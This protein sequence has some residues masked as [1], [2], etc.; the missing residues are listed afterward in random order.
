MALTQIKTTGIADDAVTLAKQAAGTDGQIIT[1]DASGN[2]VAVGPGNDGQVLTSTAAG[3]PPA[4]EDAAAGGAALTGSTNNT[5]TT[6]T[7]AN[8]IQGEANLT[9]DGTHLT[10]SD[11]DL[12][13]GTAGHGIDFSDTGDTAGMTNELLDFYEEG[14]WTITDE[15]SDGVTFTSQDNTYTRVGRLVFIKA[16]FNFPNSG[17]S[18]AA[19]KMGGIPFPISGHGTGVVAKAADITSG[20]GYAN[21]VQML[22]NSTGIHG[23]YDGSLKVGAFGNSQFQNRNVVFSVCYQTT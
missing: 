6:V 21:G 15:T 14:T 7:G 9:F 23:V 18:G 12:V 2:P 3:A 22:V 11:G 17:L 10:I 13:I 1:Y 16:K 8:A 4:F 19:M 5:I 20:A